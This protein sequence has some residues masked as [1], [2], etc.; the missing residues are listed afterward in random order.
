MSEKFETPKRP[1]PVTFCFAETNPSILCP[2]VPLFPHSYNSLLFSH[3][4]LEASFLLFR[5]L[6]QK[7]LHGMS[8]YTPCKRQ[9]RRLP[10][11][12]L[13]YT[14]VKTARSTSPIGNSGSEPRAAAN[15]PSRCSAIRQVYCHRARRSSGQTQQI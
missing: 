2:S 6:K 13:K 14:T 8:S 5:K 11:T 12:S 1:F 7:S 3:S 15:H 4:P 9:A 10:K